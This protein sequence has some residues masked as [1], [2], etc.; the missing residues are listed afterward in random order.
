MRTMPEIA[1]IEPDQIMYLQQTFTQ[2]KA[3]W[4]LVNL[5]VNSSCKRRQF[6]YNPNDGSGV[7]VYVLDTGIQAKNPEFSG[8]VRKGANFVRGERFRDLNGHGTH[9]A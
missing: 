7:N 5:N 1:N 4:G 8:R 6:Q 2:E 9:V 3:H